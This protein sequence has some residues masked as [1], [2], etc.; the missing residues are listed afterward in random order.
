MENKV[1]TSNQNPSEN[2]KKKDWVLVVI[3]TL[4]IVK[5]TENYVLFK[6]PNGYSAIINAKFLRKKEHE[7]K[8]FLSVPENYEINCNVREKV[9]GKWA[10]TKSYSVKAVELKSLVDD[11]NKKSSKPE[12]QLPF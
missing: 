9:D 4:L 8:I 3:R 10:T 2:S 7:D 11:Y 5:R 6:L 1:Q 12:D